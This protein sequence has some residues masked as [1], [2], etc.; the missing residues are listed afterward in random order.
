MARFKV[1]ITS[2]QQVT[3]EVEADLYAPDAVLR[4]LVFDKV[5]DGEAFWVDEAGD[6]QVLLLTDD[7]DYFRSLG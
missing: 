3:A 7:A 4:E 5:E 1:T 6:T 2:E